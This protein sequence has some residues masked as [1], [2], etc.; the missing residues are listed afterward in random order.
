MKKKNVISFE[1]IN[2]IKKKKKVEDRK[3]QKILC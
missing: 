3:C 1:C 2:K